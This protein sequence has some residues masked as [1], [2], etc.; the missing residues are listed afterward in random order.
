MSLQLRND[1]RNSLQHGYLETVHL[2]HDTVW[3]H[4]AATSVLGVLSHWRTIEYPCF[5]NEF[6]REFPKVDK[7][8]KTVYRKLITR[9]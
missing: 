9:C 1:H 7:Q 8:G 4:N 3:V 6:E 2:K 5:D